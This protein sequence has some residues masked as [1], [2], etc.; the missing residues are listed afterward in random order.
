M[1]PPHK[2]PRIKHPE[3]SPKKKYTHTQRVG[4]GGADWSWLL[5][6]QWQAPSLIIEYQG[7]SQLLGATPSPTS[8][9]L[10]MAAALE[11]CR[12]S[13]FLTSSARGSKSPK[14]E[15]SYGQE[16]LLTLSSG[17]LSRPSISSMPSPQP[18]SDRLLSPSPHQILPTHK[19]SSKLYHP[20]DYQNKTTGQQHKVGPPPLPGSYPLS[21]GAGWRG[22]RLA[23]PR[24]GAPPQPSSG[25]ALTHPPE[26]AAARG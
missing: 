24:P 23:S 21:P 14:R 19:A 4:G 1:E 9:R 2:T 20:N 13:P 18:I 17:V 10:G 5:P 22:P 7:P 3:A 6:Q 25:R 15:V 16:A 12:F 11:K 8:L 26:D